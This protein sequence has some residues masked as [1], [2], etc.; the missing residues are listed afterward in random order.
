MRDAD[1]NLRDSFFLRDFGLDQEETASLT[2]G[3]ELA[4]YYEAVVEA[5]APPT[6]AANWVRMEVV[7]LLNELDCGIDDENFPLKPDVL[8]QLVAKAEKKELSNTVAKDILTLLVK[9]KI[10]L[11][12]AIA[13]SGASAARLTG[14]ALGEVIRKIMAA[15]P[16]VVE[17]IRSG[18]DKKG[19]KM[20]FL[21]GLI[22]KETRGQA[23][24]KE[25][26]ESLER[27]LQ[28]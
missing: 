7:R 15:N 6:R 21:Q 2:E 8:A 13:R 3:K 12:E 25:A 24:P 5:G 28:A 16:D 10:S 26:A 14:D 27:L 18:Q 20:K 17:T 22:M 19:G 23:D 11:P 4:A 1:L 9:E